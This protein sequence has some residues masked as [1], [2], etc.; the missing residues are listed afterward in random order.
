MLLDHGY[1]AYTEKPCKPLSLSPL[2]SLQSYLSAPIPIV[3][4][5]KPSLSYRYKSFGLCY[6]FRGVHGRYNLKTQSHMSDLW[7]LTSVV[8]FGNHGGDFRRFQA[9]LRVS[10]TPGSLTNSLTPKNQTILASCIANLQSG[11][12]PR[13]SNPK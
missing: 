2:L 3:Y 11:K 1:F 7:K 13:F 6:P 8:P 9:F 10:T 5:N 4:T 12:P